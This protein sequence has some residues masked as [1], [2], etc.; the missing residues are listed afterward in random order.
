MSWFALSITN[1]FNLDDDEDTSQQH[2]PNTSTDPHLEPEDDSS[3]PSSRGFKEDLSEITKTLTTKLWGIA[4]FLAPPPSDHHPNSD[5]SDPEPVSG[6][7][8][9]CGDRREVSECNF[10]AVE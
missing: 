6:I 5:P 4:S 3:S 10:K 8:R 9:L 2:S 7:R 1:T